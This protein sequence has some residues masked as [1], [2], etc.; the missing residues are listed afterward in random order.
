MFTYL[1]T[2]AGEFDFMDFEI[3]FVF[4]FGGL[5]SAFIL[6]FWQCFNNINREGIGN[7]PTNL[8]TAAIVIMVVGL[9]SF[10]LVYNSRNEYG[11]TNITIQS[12]IHDFC[13]VQDKKRHLRITAPNLWDTFYLS[14]PA[15][16]AAF[17][18][19]KENIQVFLIWSGQRSSDNVEYRVEFANLKK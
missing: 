19:K 3:P 7:S 17:D 11:R 14:D 1:Y 16:L 8:L 12:Q 10:P 13:T 5:F 6:V 4:F 2:V 18:E 9:V 15:F